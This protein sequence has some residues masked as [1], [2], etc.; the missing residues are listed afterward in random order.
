MTLSYKKM[1]T[2]RFSIQ[3]KV[4]C[5]QF[6][7]KKNDI[8]TYHREFR[9]QNE[10]HCYLKRMKSTY[11]RTTRNILDISIENYYIFKH[12]SILII[13]MIL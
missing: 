8:F 9:V 7:G 10:Y 11:Y 12:P 2:S 5:M 1:S 3:L 4:D 6:I 13:L